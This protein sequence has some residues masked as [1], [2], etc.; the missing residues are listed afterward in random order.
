MEEIEYNEGNI[1]MTHVLSWASNDNS[2]SQGT[3]TE[4][5]IRQGE[6]ITIDDDIEGGPAAIIREMDRDLGSAPPNA[7]APTEEM[8]N[9]TNENNENGQ[10][11]EGESGQITADSVDGGEEKT[12]ATADSPPPAIDD[13][14]AWRIKIKYLNDDMKV[15]EAKPSQSLGAFKKRNFESEL[16]A[17]KLVRL[18]FN[19]KVLQPDGASL[20]SFALF[21][22]CV[23]HCLVH[24]MPANRTQPAQQQQQQQQVQVYQ[25]RDVIGGGVG[26]LLSGGQPAEEQQ[27]QADGEGGEGNYSAAHLMRTRFQQWLLQQWTRIYCWRFFTETLLFAF[28]VGTVYIR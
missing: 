24:N 17:N 22:D 7:A 6:L 19:G 1:L 2:I 20:R 15:V 10:R 12:N 16:A 26:G 27:Q 3:N 9:C 13:E 8:Q 25:E 18:V 23:V 4:A 21:E 5:S 11:P 28:T 14:S